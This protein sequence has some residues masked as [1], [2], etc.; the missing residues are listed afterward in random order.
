MSDKQAALKKARAVRSLKKRR[1]VERAI[2]EL[3]SNH[4]AITFKSIAI[5]AGVSRQYLYN[6][7]KDSISSE[8]DKSRET[9][10]TIDGIKIPQ[11]TPEEYRHIEALLRNKMA[12]LKKDLTKARR[13]L[14]T[15]KQMLERERGQSEHWRQLWIKTRSESDI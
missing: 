4:E 2:N 1:D 10:Q 14:A 13:E 3:K 8:R 15:T 6:N 9:I 5:L 12:R 7:F 11:R